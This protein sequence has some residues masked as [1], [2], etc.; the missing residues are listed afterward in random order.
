MDYFLH[1]KFLNNW[2]LL[3]AVRLPTSIGNSVRFN[4]P[5]INGE[6]L[7][8]IHIVTA[9]ALTLPSAEKLWVCPQ[10]FRGG[11]HAAP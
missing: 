4:W 11:P 2:F 10:K 6:S 3:D 9:E 7:H 1:N 5:H 8:F